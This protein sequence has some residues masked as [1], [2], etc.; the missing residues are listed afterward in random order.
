ME[1]ATYMEGM[2]LLLVDSTVDFQQ[3]TCWGS[4][5]REFTENDK[6]EHVPSLRSQRSFFK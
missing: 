6:K 3:S 1:Y 2:I 4:L 5:M